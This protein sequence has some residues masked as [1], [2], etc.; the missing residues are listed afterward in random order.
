[1]I[2]RANN[3]A[4]PLAMSVMDACWVFAFAWMVQEVF[5]KGL[6]PY[7][8]PNAL[9]LALLWFLGWS[10]AR[11]AIN[12]NLN[13]GVAQVLT[14]GAGIAITAGLLLALYPLSADTSTGLWVGRALL[15]GLTCLAVWVMG[16]LRTIDPPDFSVVFKRF[17]AGL[18]AIGLSFLVA[19]VLTGFSAGSYLSGMS[20]IPMWFIGASLV[21]MALGNRELVRRETGSADARFWTPVLLGCVL[22][23]LLL[24]VLGGALN[25]ETIFGALTTA[26]SWTIFAVAYLLY[27]IFYF[28]FSI[29]NIDLPRF[30]RD[31]QQP[32]ISPELTDPMADFRRQ[33][34]EMDRQQPPP[35]DLGNIFTLAAVVLITA[36]ILTVLVVVGRKLKRTQEDRSRNLEEDRERFGS[37]ALLKQQAG[38]WWER[39]MSRLLRKKPSQTTQAEIDELAALRG[40]PELSGTLSIRQIYARMQSAA[41]RIGYPRAPQQTPLEYLDVLSRAMPHLR[42]DFAAIT[43]AYIEARYG[44][45]PAA[46][47]A[48]TAA[49]NAWR[50]AEPQ[51]TGSGTL[52]RGSGA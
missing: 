24:S 6:A 13:Q 34:E 41:A 38:Q 31:P 39:L 40:N 28:V 47:P 25:F 15:A 49:N 18:V 12:S 1:M 20:T 17:V 4:I 46:S 9:V 5:I 10:L 3:L 52:Y 50:H 8:V 33:I 27:S 23:V 7:Q 45:L 19:S 2:A 36:I 21:G 29:F 43:S 37:W 16:T 51:M 42:P 22:F 30:Q 48:V 26:I 35:A 14:I 32:E 44:P 11:F